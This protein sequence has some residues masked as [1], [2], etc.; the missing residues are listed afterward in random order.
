MLGPEA[1]KII[2]LILKTN[3]TLSHLVIHNIYIYIYIGATKEF[4]WECRAG[5]HWRVDR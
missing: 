3:A 4:H 2:A 5:V 1:A